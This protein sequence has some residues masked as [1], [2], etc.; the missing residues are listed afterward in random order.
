MRILVS[1]GVRVAS[2]PEAMWSAA[3]AVLSESKSA[4]LSSCM[5][6]LYAVGRPLSIVSIA[7]V[8]P[9][10]RADLPRNNSRA[11]GFFFCGMRD[12]PVE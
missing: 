7:T 6:L 3:S 1:F 8:F 9:I 5:S 4:C 12:E 2:T 10:V 11:S